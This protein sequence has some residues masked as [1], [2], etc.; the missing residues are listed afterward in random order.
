MHPVL[1]RLSNKV[2]LLLAR[3]GIA[4]HGISPCPDKIIEPGE[5]DDKGVVVIFEKGLG[6]QASGEDGLQLPFGEFLAPLLAFW[7]SNAASTGRLTS[8]F[9]MIFWKP[10]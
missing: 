9:L 5:P 7:S 3:S 6:S 2:L 8:C 4:S 10:V 1:G